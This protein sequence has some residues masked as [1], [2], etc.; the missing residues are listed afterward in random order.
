VHVVCLHNS[1]SHRR[2]NSKE[3]IMLLLLLLLY[4]GKITCESFLFVCLV[5]CLK[6]SNLDEM[7]GVRQRERVF[8]IMGLLERLPCKK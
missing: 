8:Q 3:H 2:N 4:K 7:K 5:G 6:W 1:L